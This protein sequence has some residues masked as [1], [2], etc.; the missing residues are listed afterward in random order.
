[1]SD[2]NAFRG[3]SKDRLAFLDR[4]VRLASLLAIVGYIE[5]IIV[6]LLMDE[7]ALTSSIY[8]Y[9]QSAY[10]LPITSG[11]VPWVNFFVEYPPLS[12]YFILF[13]ALFKGLSVFWV[14][15]I[16]GGFAL[17]ATLF[18]FSKIGASTELSANVK[19]V[20]TLLVAGL[21]L[22][23]PGLYFGLWDWYLAL[24]ILLAAV[25]LREGRRNQMWN[26][27]AF[28][29]FLKL[30]PLLSLPFM[31]R[32]SE[33][34]VKSHVTKLALL[35][36]ALN[37]PFVILSIHSAKAFVNYHRL[38]SIDC[39]SSYATV[40]EILE[41]FHLVNIERKWAYGALEVSGG[42]SAILAKISLP[43][44]LVFVVGILL[45]FRNAK[46]ND[47]GR[48]GLFLASLIAYTVL[49][50]V[51]QNNYVVWSIG[52]IS[53]GL[54]VDVFRSS[55]IQRIASLAIVLMIAGYIQDRCFDDFTGNLVHWRMI[56]AN[57]TRL[58]VNSLVVWMMLS[59][60]LLKDDS[61]PALAS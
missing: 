1:M 20:S 33:V 61:S 45:Y 60:A 29:S 47:L 56:F 30:M 59:N 49:S 31:V 53:A 13:P 38:R 57:T 27:L 40:L 42:P 18:V 3:L 46:L 48:F 11:K 35:A 52:A 17:V 44:F 41:R 34:G 22:A 4:N 26:W 19:R 37:L 36:L 43:L 50:K 58:L 16:R 28:G 54:I 21:G 7:K 6:Y 39:F 24:T 51:S 23:T 25:A 8:T 12:T 5:F 10:Y 9:Y 14:S 2:A 15:A 55:E 32:R